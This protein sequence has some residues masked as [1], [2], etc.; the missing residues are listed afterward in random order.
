MQR[1]ALI[2]GASSGLGLMLRLAFLQQG[3][4][5]L[6]TTHKLD[7]AQQHDLLLW[8]ATRGEAGMSS[9]AH[10]V[11]EATYGAGINVLVNNAGV[12][13][14]CE[15]GDLTEAFIA[16]IQQVNFVAPVMLVRELM[17]GNTLGRGGVVV[18]VISDAAWRPMR[19]SLAYNCAK[20]ALDMATKQMARELTKPR[21]VSVIGVR[22]GKMRGTGMSNYID[23]SVQQLRGWSPEQAAEY[24]RQ[25]SV[26]GLEADPQ[27][28]A[29]FIVHVA[30]SPLAPSMSGACLDLVG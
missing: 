1:T 10:H 23:K 28:V 29:N 7:E 22:P 30:T 11:W 2:T 6:G 14:I 18:N 25:N 3:W 19:H 9:L 12:N 13:A 15:F 20:A 8:D 26:S 4:A 16:Q 5:V 17:A 24:Y 27:H 21:G